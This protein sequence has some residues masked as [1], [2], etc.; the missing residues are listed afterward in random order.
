M[1]PYPGS[2]DSHISNSTASLVNNHAACDIHTFAYQ[3]SSIS[4]RSAQFFFAYILSSDCC[5]FARACLSIY[6]GLKCK[7]NLIFSCLHFLR[8]SYLGFGWV[9]VHTRCASIFSESTKCIFKIKWRLLM[10]AWLFIWYVK[11]IC[12]SRA[13][14]NVAKGSSRVVLVFLCFGNQI[15]QRF[16]VNSDFNQKSLGLGMQ[17]RDCGKNNSSGIPRNTHHVCLHEQR[18]S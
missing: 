13:C 9:Y 18:R 17:S 4:N 15:N 11:Y 3:L 10:F 6:L 2:I 1:R 5:I 14:G 16:Y 8:A 7:S 12:L